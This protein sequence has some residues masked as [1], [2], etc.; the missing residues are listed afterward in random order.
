MRLL[1]EQSAE[2]KRR[3][4]CKYGVG[5]KEVIEGVKAATIIHRGTTVRLLG[6]SIKK[7]N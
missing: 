7:I 6:D 2:K 5:I 3:K 4:Q 1:S